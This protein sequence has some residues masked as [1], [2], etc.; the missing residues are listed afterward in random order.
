VRSVLLD[1]GPQVALFDENDAHHERFDALVAQLAGAGLRLVTTW[2]CV[3][4]AAY[5]LGAPNRFELLEWVECGGAQVYP[6]EAHHLADLVKWMRKYTDRRREMDFADA[7]LYWLAHETG[8]TEI[9]T[10]DRGDFERYRLPGGG[11]F[12]LL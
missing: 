7:S 6:F 12:E 1:A 10:V 4:E 2:P 8:I 9:L 3:V 11:H 5:L